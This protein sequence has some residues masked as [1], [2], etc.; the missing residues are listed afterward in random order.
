MR[1]KL[2]FQKWV[3]LAACFLIMA[4]AFSIVNNITT[5]FLDPVTKDLGVSNSAFSLIFTIGALITSL[6]SPI[7]GQLVTKI[8]IKIIMSVGALLAGVGFFCY[9]FAKQIWV[10]YLI[11]IIVAIGISCL[12][13]IPIA[14]TLTHWFKDKKGLALGISTAG[15]GTGSFIWMQIV[16]RL[17]LNKGYTFTYAILGIIILVVCLPLSIFVI[18]MPADTPIE[19][20]KKETFSYK[21]IHWSS[22][23]ILFAS[24]LFLLGLCISGTKMHI[25]PYLTYLHHPLTFNANVGSTQAIFALAG[26]LIGG[27][28]FDKLKLRTSIIILIS[29]ALVSYLCLIFGSFQPLLFIFAALFGICLC[30]PSLLPTYG[31]S[32]LFGQEHYAIHLGFITMIFTLGGSIGPLI[33]GFIADHLDYT[34]VWI[35]YFAI[36]IIYLILLLLALKRK[37][38]SD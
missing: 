18:S 9:S 29:M 2:E 10:F 16:S 34:V 28:I 11:A 37:K 24:G 15:A 30:L 13:T 14:T 27:Y 4:V 23:L 17:L 12:T 6:M 19:T 1:K 8:N 21:D 32:A 35:I 25:Q 5:L 7:V 31:T 33:S 36:T 3:V 22:S 26:S 20:K 38:T